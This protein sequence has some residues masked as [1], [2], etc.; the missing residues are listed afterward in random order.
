M[1]RTLFVDFNAFFASVEQQLRPELRGRP[2]AVVPMLTD[3]T[4]CIAASYEARAFGVKTGTGVA[5]AK[6]L[7]P[8]LVLVEARVKEYVKMHHAALEAADHCL[9][10]H[11][12]HSIDEFSCRFMGA[13]REPARARTLAV[14]MKRVL[15]ERLGEFVKCSVGLGPNT[16]L[17]KMASNQVKPDGLTIIDVPDLPRWYNEWNLQCVPGIATQMELRLRSHGVSTME[18]FCALDAASARKAWGSLVGEQFWRMLRGEDVDLSRSD[19]RRTISHQHVLPPAQR[20]ASEARTVAVRLL[21]KACKRLRGEGYLTRRLTLVVKPLQG[22]TWHAD[23][24][25]PDCD[26]SLTLVG[27][28]GGLWERSPFHAMLRVGVVLSELVPASCA[29]RVLYGEAERRG[30]LSHMMDRIN[31]RYHDTKVYF[32]AMHGA[33]RAAP[34]RIAFTHVPGMESFSAEEGHERERQ[35]ARQE[36]RLPRAPTDPFDGISDIDA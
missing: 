10:V 8:R 34:V 23:A 14:L 19:L 26:D 22:P 16:L 4:C 36:A 12:V 31:D 28:L 18:Q 33:I 20:P 32:G 13:E 5:E 1:L 15:R 30:R 9:P 29:T 11:A 25:F 17:A 2:V 3:S 6:R 21:D 35:R 27:V 7:C 24:A